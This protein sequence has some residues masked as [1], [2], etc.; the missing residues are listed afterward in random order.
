MKLLDT[1]ILLSDVDGL[2]TADPAVNQAAEPIP[3]VER[4]TP[5]IEAADRRLIQ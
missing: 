5:A 2:Y 3:L 1:L 4:I